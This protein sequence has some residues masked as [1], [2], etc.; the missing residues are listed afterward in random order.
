MKGLAEKWLMLLLVV[1]IT[2]VSGI[3][4]AEEDTSP[5]EEVEVLTTL[6]Q[7]MQ[8]RIS[9]D[10]RGTPIDDVIRLMAEQADVDI[11][12]SPKVVGEVTTRLTDV[13]LSEALTNILAAHGYGY[14]TTKNMIRIAPMA[15]LTERAE[16]LTSRI[17]RITY[18]D[19][20][21]VETALRKFISNR[22]S[23]S[24][25][26]GTSNIIVTDTESKIKAIDTF[27]T[28]IDR[29]TPQVLVEARIYDV[30][31]TDHLDLGV[32]WSAGR[33]T[34]YDT[35][36]GVG[37]TGPNP[38]A[39][40]IDSFMTS[41]FDG[42]VTQSDSTTGLFRI[43]WLNSAIDI[44]MAIRAQKEVINAKL[45][46]NPRVMV[47]DNEKA[48]IKII[49]EIPYQELT[50]SSG[51]GSIGT[52]S[53]RE[54]GVTLLVT[55]HI[56]RGEMVRLH[57]L[58]EFS[59]QAGN[60]TLG[61]LSGTTYTQPQVD[62]RAAESTLLLKSSQTMVLGGLRKKEVTDQE[63]K[64]PLL[65]DIPIVGNLFKFKAEETLFSEVVVF[66]T[67]YIVEN[68][69]LSE[70]EQTIFEETKFGGPC[71]RLSEGEK[72]GTCLTQCD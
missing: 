3:A 9:I 5:T 71:P 46:A 2:A 16:V 60:V 36:G 72:D 18:A 67:P 25:N 31:C 51:G 38:T 14:V 68:G 58:P 59:V 37:T 70:D 22:G 12:K 47:L 65:G 6:E 15:E 69:E 52:V 53:F 24:A 40:H 29:I 13:P 33:N 32:E 4:L 20:E 49:R 41:V 26:V 17:Y 39:G 54:V 7:R 21:E 34:T 55:P 63:N 50:E 30:T 48:T 62:K 35:T 11:V 64:V 10:F 61:N 45:L 27:I 28:E 42:T 23:I 8:K 56:T 43:G 66:I 44:D 57:V 1:S 19:V